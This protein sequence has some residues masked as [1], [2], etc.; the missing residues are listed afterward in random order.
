VRPREQ[1]ETFEASLGAERLGQRALAEDLT[2]RVHGDAELASVLRTTE[3]LFGGGDL[4]EIG[5]D[6]LDEALAA[7]PAI[8]VPRSRFEGEGALVVDLLAEVGACQSKS[9]ARRQL[10]A[11]GIAVNG[12]SL[13]TS[14]VDTRVTTKD[15]IDNRLLVLRRGKRNNYVI[16][17]A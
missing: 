15:L 2:R 7:A 14:S 16:R 9:D 10:G 13:G 11:G 5:G 12:V 17:V 3:K 8:T 4:R 6:I 1:I